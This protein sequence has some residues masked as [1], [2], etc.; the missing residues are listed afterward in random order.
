MKKSFSLIKTKKKIYFFGLIK[1]LK[2]LVIIKRKN[3]KKIN[4]KFYS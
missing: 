4:F 3:E 2:I 1:N